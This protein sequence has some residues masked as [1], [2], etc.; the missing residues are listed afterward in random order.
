MMRGFSRLG[1][2]A[3]A[4]EWASPTLEIPVL[5][6]LESLREKE[7]GIWTARALLKPSLSLPYF[8]G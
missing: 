2:G 5:T 6:P 8:S 4:D 7:A 3:G 1:T